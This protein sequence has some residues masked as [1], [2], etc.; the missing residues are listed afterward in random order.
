MRVSAC[1]SRIAMP[2]CPQA[3]KLEAAGKAPPIRRHVDGASVPR[4]AYV[5]LLL[6][7]LCHSNSR[8]TG[9]RK[10]A[11][12]TTRVLR[13]S[14]VTQSTSSTLALRRIAKTGKPGSRS[15]AS[16]Q[17]LKKHVRQTSFFAGNLGTLGRLLAWSQQQVS[18]H[19]R[20]ADKGLE[21]L[22]RISFGW[23]F[24]RSSLRLSDIVTARTCSRGLPVMGC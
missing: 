20:S 23:F 18:V 10:P 9:Y 11:A 5:L 24:G 4:V 2:L 15:S 16:V 13:K 14:Q 17:T 12:Y 22:R 21:L 8:C 3:K 6:V 1:D 7:N 19:C